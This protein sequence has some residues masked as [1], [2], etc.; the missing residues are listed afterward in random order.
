MPKKDKR[1]ERKY[2]RQRVKRGYSDRDVWDIDLW[3]LSVMPK[4]LQ[5]L[6]ETRHG[7]PAEL[8]E[9]YVNDDGGMVNDKCH[10]EWDKILDRMIFL[11][12]EMNEDISEISREKV[13]YREKCKNEFFE[14][15]SKYF[16]YLWD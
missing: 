15:F 7:S 1:L 10:E 14:L 8:G 16:W 6:K 13:S 4:M 9:S 2:G 11:L 12:G 3:F 5:Q